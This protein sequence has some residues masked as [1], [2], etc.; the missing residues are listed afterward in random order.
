MN[1]TKYAL[2][3]ALAVV[4][5]LLLLQ[6]QEDYPDSVEQAGT[7]RLAETPES[8][9]VLSATPS[10]Q[11]SAGAELPRLPGAVEA[12]AAVEEAERKVVSVLTDTLELQIDTE[13]G[14]IV[15]LALPQYLK[16][17]EEGA[18]PFT[19]LSSAS[20][21]EYTAPSGL[22][23]PNGIDSD[24]RAQYS[25]TAD[26]FRLDNGAETLQV[27]LTTRTEAGVEITKR[28]GFTRDSY[29]I[30]VSYLINNQSQ[31]AFTANPFGQIRRDVFDDPS[32]AGGFG[33]TYLGFV[34]TTT[35]DP[36]YEVEFDDID[37][38][39]ASTQQTVGGWMAFSQHY[40]ISAWIPDD[41]AS[42]NFI[43]RK[44]QAGQ[45]F[46]EFTSQ[47]VNVAP[48]QSS[49]IDSR[50]YAGPK[51]QYKLAEISDNLDLT[52][53]YSFLW[54]LAAPIYWLLTRINSVISNYGFSI[55]LLTVTVKALFYKLSE[56]Q[57]RSM[58][59]MRRVMPKMQQLKESYGDDRMKMQ[60][61]TMELYKKEKINPFGGCLPMLVQMPVFIAL[62][63]VLLE[64]VELRH[65]PFMLWLTDLS[66]RDP[67]FILP[68]LMGGTMYLQTSLSPAP[69]DPMQAKVMKLMPIMMTG[70]FLWFPAG[71]V[72]YWFTN[73]ALGIAQQWY[74]TRKIEAQYEAKK[75]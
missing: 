34:S 5:Y 8:L 69:A 14:D 19:L 6:W 23:G 63:W 16:T 51:D 61:A 37:D 74:I 58:A 48:G 4:T 42:N 67:Y 12:V 53:D 3:T 52:I 55:I 49:R 21:R 72:L 24:G 75:A 57:Y 29:V 11:D 44:N 20:N 30:D 50:F 38:D 70:I 68:L 40:F 59:G 22:I 66:V 43:T 33:R 60:Q 13:G 47:A 65:A 35:E 41:Q 64:S 25:V 39:G 46:G 36:Y 10:T 56:T 45:Y 26:Q 71:L 18:D 31:Q 28:F 2:Y 62:Y 73:A 9:P 32:D 1:L 54:F 17:L 15:F 7:E 27:D